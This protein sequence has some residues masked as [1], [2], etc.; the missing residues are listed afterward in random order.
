MTGRILI[1]DRSSADRALSVAWIA[2]AFHTPLP[3]ADDEQGLALA[4]DEAPDLALVTM[5]AGGAEPAAVIA[6]L[7]AGPG[8]RMLPIIAL[9]PGDDPALR[10]AALAAGADDVFAHPADEGL[11][12]ARINS[13][14]KLRDE[15]N[16]VAATLG[17]RQAD[18]MALA[19]P[20]PA[21]EAAPRIALIAARR[22]TAL[23]WGRLVRS[24]MRSHMTILSRRDAA[25]LTATDNGPAPDIIVIEA[26]LGGEGGI[27][28]MLR[29]A[30]SG[31]FEHSLFCIVTGDGDRATAKAAFGFGAHGVIGRSQMAGEIGLRLQALL[32]RKQHKDRL[33]QVM[34]REL[35]FAVTDPLT[36]VHNR[37]YAQPLLAA[38]ARQAADDGSAFAVMVLDLD[39]FKLINDRYG[40]AAGDAVLVEVAR[41]LSDSLRL[42]DLLARIGGE[43]FLVA[44]PG[45]TLDKAHEIAERLRRAISD[46]PILLPSGERARIT[47][48]IGVAIGGSIA[49]TES[50][51]RPD[52]SPPPRNRPPANGRTLSAVHA[53]SDGHALLERADRALLSA[54]LGGRNLVTFSASAA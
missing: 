35:H 37:R 13:L 44:L 22:E 20:A 11:L 33:R 38:I 32:R 16:L 15:A 3:A 18:F 52:M 6:A 28:L 23:G 5:A 1:I 7:R 12:I 4:R 8:T 49:T 30:E 2:G 40:H 10:F 29:L 43:E 42:H 41:R 24:Q 21:F 53:L 26:D 31:P 17:A 50:C 54:K 9:A 45:I 51:S 27:P 19:E 14:L 34:E 36:G 47:A 48:S 46:T 25:E 39:R